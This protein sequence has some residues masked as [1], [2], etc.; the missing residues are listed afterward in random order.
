[1]CHH[2]SNLCRCATRYYLAAAGGA[3]YGLDH[4][5][6]RFRQDWMRPACSVPGLVLAGQDVSTAGVIGA[7]IGGVFAAI[8][9]D[10]RVVVDT[11]QCLL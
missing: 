9:V 5:P 4:G 3:S 2:L 11:V 8:A 1:M 10:K 7:A 6:K